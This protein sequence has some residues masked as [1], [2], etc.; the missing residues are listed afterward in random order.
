[1]GASTRQITA[2]SGSAL[3]Y[4]EVTYKY[5]PLV[6]ARFFGTSIL[7]SECV[8]NVR[9]G[10][11]QVLGTIA[12]TT[13]SVC[14]IYAALSLRP[15]HQPERCAYLYVTFFAA[16]TTFAAFTSISFSRLAA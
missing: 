13:A 4:V 6:S 1:M 11:S 3:I 14:T 5:E 2:G 7:R 12:G 15:V 10:N 8:C 16:S 9:E